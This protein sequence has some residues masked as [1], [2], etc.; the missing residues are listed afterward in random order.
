MVNEHDFEPVL[1]LPAPLPAG[2]SILWQGKPDWRSLA[3]HAMYVRLIMAWFMGLIVWGI[4]FG[5]ADGLSAYDLTLSLLRLVVLGGIAV[6]VFALFAWL[7]ARTTL[8]T[9][10]TRRVVMRYGI[11]FPMALQIPFSRVDGADLCPRSNGTGDLTLT[12][13]P[14]ERIAY[15]ALW[16]HARPWT[17]ARARPNLRGISDAEAVARV[18]ARALAGSVPQTPAAVVLPVETGSVN[19]PVTA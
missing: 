18:L 4:V 5:A 17:F 8:Y 13:L 10:T 19:M 15:L 2:E 7:V 16:P 1:G 3:R 14:G 12:L 11:A 9:I 6:G